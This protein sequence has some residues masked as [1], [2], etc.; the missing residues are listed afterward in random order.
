MTA[1][2]VLT[3]VGRMVQG[4]PFTPNTTNAT[5]APLVHKS[6]GQPREEF[7][8]SVAIAKTD[9]GWA[10]FMQSI[11]AVAVAGFPGGEYNS[12][13]FHWKIIDGDD[14]KFAAR[15]GFAGHYVVRCT[16]GYRPKL[17]QSDGNGGYQELLD[18]NA[19]KRGYYVRA[20]LTVKSNG[21]Q[22]SPGVYLN[23]SHVELIGYGT[24]I[25]SGPDAAT[26]FGGAPVA[27]PAGASA[28]P[29]APVNTVAPAPVAAP[30]VAPA[31][32]PVSVP[33]PVVAPVGV[34]VAA[35]APVAPAPVA[36][37][38]AVQPAPSFL[39]PGG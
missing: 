4:H 13:E 11:Q 18:P 38:A 19:L 24:E 16:S 9:P 22:Q 31:M 6:T 26:V 3:P 17:Y 10:A 37:P 8:F 29:V 39:T 28:T 23:P 33:A 21:S 20:A 30:V 7:F 1:E 25:Q 36:A 15:E 2:H 5:G 12:P 35:P 34:P 32:A 14:P 27:L